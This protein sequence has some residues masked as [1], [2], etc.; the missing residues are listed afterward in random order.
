M[1]LHTH[2]QFVPLNSSFRILLIAFPFPFS[3]S[4]NPLPPSILLLSLP[5]LPFSPSFYSPYLP[6]LSL[7]PP[8]SLPLF[9]FSPSIPSLYPSYP[10]PPSHPSPHLTVS[11]SLHFPPSLSSASQC[12][13]LPRCVSSLLL[14]MTSQASHYDGNTKTGMFIFCQEELTYRSRASPTTAVS[15]ALRS[16]WLYSIH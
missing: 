12:Q 11:P 1:G 5:L 10:F 15:T 9:P 4:I 16:S 7:F 14:C 2:F 13:S 6:S 3:P 8:L